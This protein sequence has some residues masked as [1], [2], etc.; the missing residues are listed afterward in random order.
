MFARKLLV[1]GVCIMHF[2]DYLC[3]QLIDRL[4]PH[5]PSII[6]RVVDAR[7][8]EEALIKAWKEEE[9]QEVRCR[10]PTWDGLRRSMI[11]HINVLLYIGNDEAR[12]L[13]QGV[14]P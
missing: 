9:K 8:K 6:D 13:H 5:C 4:I 2:S 7:Q 1:F 11:S 3:R 12:G 10:I 14:G